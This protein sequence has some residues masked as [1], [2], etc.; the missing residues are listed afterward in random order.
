[1]PPLPFLFNAK[2]LGNQIK[3]HAYGK[4]NKGYSG[5]ILGIFSIW[6]PSKWC[7]KSRF[8]FDLYLLSRIVRDI[9]N[10]AFN[11]SIIQVIHFEDCITPSPI[12]KTIDILYVLMFMVILFENA[13]LHSWIT[14]F[15]ACI[16]WFKE[17]RIF[18]IFLLFVERGRQ[19]QPY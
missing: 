15:G 3:M 11:V 5:S 9:N 6:N 13:E 4:Y 2:G 16:F 18:P 7:R 10:N 1:M 19:V 8:S 12:L 17:I 14:G